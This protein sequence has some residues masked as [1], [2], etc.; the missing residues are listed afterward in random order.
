MGV[1]RTHK[2]ACDREFQC[3]LCDSA[4]SHKRS[5]VNHMKVKHSE[6][7]LKDQSTNQLLSTEMEVLEEAG[8]TVDLLGME[9]MDKPTTLEE[10]VTQS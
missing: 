5:R 3:E 6:H 1:K 10:N 7:F 9:L 2:E 4:Y 8:V